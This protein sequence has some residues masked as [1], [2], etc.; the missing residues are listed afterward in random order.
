VEDLLGTIAMSLG[1]D[2]K[3]QNQ[4]NVGRPIRIVEPSARPIKEVLA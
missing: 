4:S 2:I 3:K 1:I